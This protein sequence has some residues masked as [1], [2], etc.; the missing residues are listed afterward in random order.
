MREQWAKEYIDTSQIKELIDKEKKM[1][2][3]KEQTVMV[4]DV[5]EAEKV[6][7]TMEAN[8]STSK[9]LRNGETEERKYMSWATKFVGKAY[10]P[11]Q[12]LKDRDIIKIK[13]AGIENYYNKES[14]KLYVTL[15]IFDFEKKA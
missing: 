11:A 2:Q 3:I 1:L 10:E 12:N 7:N 6:K 5:K 13:E 15:V 4:W 14:E 8:V 9:I